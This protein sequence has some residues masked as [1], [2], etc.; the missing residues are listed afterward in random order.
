MHSIYT[1][2]MYTCSPASCILQISMSVN[3][4]H[5]HA[6]PMPTALTQMAALTAHVGKASKEMGSTVQV[7]MINVLHKHSCVLK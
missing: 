3:W 5:I 2:Y 7:C 4:R 6:V 1:M